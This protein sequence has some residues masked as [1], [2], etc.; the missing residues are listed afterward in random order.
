[1]ERNGPPEYQQDC[2][3]YH[4]ERGLVIAM[5]CLLMVLVAVVVL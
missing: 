3:E 4:P 2:E 5:V 1:M